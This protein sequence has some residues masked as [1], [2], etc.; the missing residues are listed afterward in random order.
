MEK[1][2]QGSTGSPPLPQRKDIRIKN[3]DY[4]QSGYY[5]VTICTLDRKNILCEIV[6]ADDSEKTVGAG[7]HARPQVRLSQIGFELEK[8]IKENEITEYVIMPNHIHLVI[9][10]QTGNLS[11]SDIVRN[12]KSFSTYKFWQMTGGHRDPPLQN[13]KEVLWQRNYYEHIIRNE[14]EYL[15]ILEYVKNNPLKWELDKY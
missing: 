10:L 7:L 14:K 5:F 6:E 2:E 9:K 13:K 8:I 4:S 15:E 1:Y 3:Y 12:I 11:L